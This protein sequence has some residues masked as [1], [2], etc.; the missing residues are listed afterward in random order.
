MPNRLLRP[1]ACAAL[2]LLLSCSVPEEEE[3]PATTSADEVR[4]ELE[5]KMAAGLA[6]RKM[7]NSF[8]P[9]TYSLQW[10]RTRV[11][12]SGDYTSIEIPLASGVNVSFHASDTLPARYDVP[13]SQEVLVIK[14]HERTTC[15]IFLT[16]LIP[17]EETLARF[18][19]DVTPAFNYHGDKSSFS[20]IV[21]YSTL[22]GCNLRIERYAAGEVIFSAS[23]LTWGSAAK[24]NRQRITRHIPPFECSAPPTRSGGPD[25]PI[26]IDPVYC[27]PCRTFL[28]MNILPGMTY[29]D[30]IDLADHLCDECQQT[31]ISHIAPDAGGGNG[32]GTG[33]TPIENKSIKTSNP[34]LQTVMNEILSS[35]NTTASMGTLLQEIVNNDQFD[36]SPNA[37]TSVFDIA[38]TRTLS[39]FTLYYNHDFVNSATGLTIRVPILH[40]IA[41]IFFAFEE[42]A[43]PSP[44]VSWTSDRIADRDHEW[45]TRSSDYM[46]L[47]HI[48]CP[49]LTREEYDALKYAGTV[50]SPVFTD[51]PLEEQTK[52]KT[53]LQTLKIP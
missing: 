36:C 22:N 16:S 39:R 6:D 5:Q 27:Y 14:D 4:M 44:G 43:M 52:V 34:L 24:Y 11:Y 13:V 23:L 17:D 41:H 46:E 38:Y 19:D 53:I 1:T 25:N 32:G 18:G 29:Q 35:I 42:N 15:G 49:G 8:T 48:V 37:A 26:P 51:L 47:L 3:T 33:G 21:L 2:C 50:L 28:Q 30:L 12:T 7:P 9:D 31:Y 10:E 20:G 45:M 40:E